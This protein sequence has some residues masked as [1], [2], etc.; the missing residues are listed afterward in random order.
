MLLRLLSPT[1]PLGRGASC[2]RLGGAVPCQRD[3]R[4]QHSPCSPAAP[5]SRAVAFASPGKATQCVSGGHAGLRFAHSLQ[6]QAV[7]LGRR[8]EAGKWPS[9]SPGRSPRTGQ[10]D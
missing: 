2:G 4:A 9:G 6:G 8:G 1:G 7:K 3:R 10:G 5:E